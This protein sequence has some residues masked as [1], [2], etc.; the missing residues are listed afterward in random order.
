MKQ[1]SRDSELQV[2]SFLQ[3]MLEGSGISLLLS[4]VI[5]WCGII[6]EKVAWKMIIPNDP[7]PIAIIAIY[8]TYVTFKLKPL[9]ANNIRLTNIFRANQAG[10]RTVAD[11]VIALVVSILS[12]G[13][14]MLI[15][16]IYLWIS[17][18]LSV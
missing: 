2:G 13:I 10:M 6:L 5:V 4:F 7:F 12:L 16:I 15:M 9:L 8:I 14:L 18:W 17:K 1:I 3:T 11:F